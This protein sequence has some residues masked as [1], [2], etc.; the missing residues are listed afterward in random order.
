MVV[1]TQDGLLRLN[2]IWDVGDWRKRRSGSA[3][4][5]M[6]KEAGDDGATVYR[7][8]DIGLQPR[9]DKLVFAIRRRCQSKSE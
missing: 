4:S 8:N 9:F 7:C 6:V 2:N 1:E 5:G 3:T